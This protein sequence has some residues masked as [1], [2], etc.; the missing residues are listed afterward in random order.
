MDDATYQ[1]FDLDAETA[2][3]LL[4]WQLEMGVDVPVMDA[5]VDRFALPARSAPAA[6]PPP[7]VLE[8]S[9]GDDLAP[10]WPRPRRWRKRP[11]ALVRWPLPRK[12]STGSS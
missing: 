11:A 1:G 12:L 3:A 6:A 9:G 8:L 5:P 2:L 4:D 10:E 7:A